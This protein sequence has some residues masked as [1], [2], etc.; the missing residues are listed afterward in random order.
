[1]KTKRIDENTSKITHLFFLAALIILG[2]AYRSLLDKILTVTGG[3]QLVGQWSQV[4][5]LMD[6][7]VAPTFMGVAMGVTI[8]TAQTNIKYHK[9]ILVSGILIG[10]ITVLIYVVTAIF[11]NKPLAS[12]IGL[13]N[14]QSNLQ[15]WAIAGGFANT[16]LLLLN[17]YWLGQKKIGLVLTSTLIL[18]LPSIICAWICSNKNT[19]TEL[20]SIAQTYTVTN[21]VII[22]YIALRK[23]K[24]I[25]KILIEKK[26]NLYK[27]MMKLIPFTVTG[28]TVG[29]LT[30]LSTVII[31]AEMYREMNWE[32]VGI[33]TALWRT[34]DWILSIVNSALYYYVLPKASIEAAAGR[35]S[36][37]M[38]NV[39]IILFFPALVT[40][41]ILF[42]FQD[43]ILAKLYSNNIEI[44]SEII[45]YFWIGD[46]FRMYSGILI[47]GLYTLHANRA[48]T[49]GEFFSQPLLA[50]ILALGFANTL[51]NVGASHLITYIIFAIINT[52]FFYLCNKDSRSKHI[53]EKYCDIK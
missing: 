12:F 20:I 40:F 46:I 17:G 41:G 16:P 37:M 30:P 14:N 27:I 33:A 36:K 22:G 42:S 11:W 4:Q 7:V 6:L 43:F 28:F 8:F 1:M 45:T 52:C 44:K 53:G 21:L 49:I 13:N 2:P 47:F 26:T 32:S 5:S 35:S 48:I 39:F 3:I 31:R 10:L 51:I 29:I 9:E 24:S 38:I 25:I 50:F 15:T 18:M 23:Y 34:S 19:G